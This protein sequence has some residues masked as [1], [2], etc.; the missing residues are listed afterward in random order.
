MTPEELLT[1]TRSVRQR[2]D[3]KRPVP[4]EVLLDCLRI[5]LQAP[6]GGNRQGW[7]WMF[8]TD[9]EKKERIAELYRKS[10]AAYVK[11]DRPAY[12]RDDPRRAQL[13]RVARSAQF[14]ADHYGEVP[15][16][17]IPCIEGRPE[18]ALNDEIAG[19]YGSIIPAAWSFMLAA[20]LHGLACAYTTLHLTYEREVA[21]IL[22]IDYDRY[23]QVALLTVGYFTGDSFHAA[24]RLPPDAVAHWNEW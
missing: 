20:R 3:F 10:W 21:E 19:L 15:A 14:L 7:Q 23:A 18:G 8:V 1:T 5:A 11:Q 6:T 17:V 13:P 16:M 12:A 9:V 24:D 22:G 4:G 2:L